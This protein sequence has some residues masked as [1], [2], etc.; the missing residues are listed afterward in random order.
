[1]PVRPDELQPCTVRLRGLELLADIGAH[2]HEIGHP[3]P[4]RVDVELLVT[5][6]EQDSLSE[7]FDYVKIRTFAQ[8]LALQRIVLVET[9][10]NRLAQACIEHPKVRRAKVT[11]EKLKALSDAIASATVTLCCS[12]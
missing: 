8:Q 4:I 12:D 9:F 10:A 3:Q 2:A 7:V 1:M 6:P 11:V 5:F